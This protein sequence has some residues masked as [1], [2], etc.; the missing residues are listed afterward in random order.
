MVFIFDLYVKTKSNKYIF[1]DSKFSKTIHMKLNLS[2]CP[3]KDI[4]FIGNS[5]GYYH[6]STDLFGKHGIK[7]YNYSVT[8][9][10]I[11]DFLWM[12]KETIKFHPKKIALVF[13]INELYEQ[14]R[15]TRDPEI[16]DILA[17]I[18]S[19]QSY[20]FIFQ[21]S[22]EY[23][24]SR[25]T[26]WDLSANVLLHIQQLFDSFNKHSL[27][28]HNVD[29]KNTDNNSLGF[30]SFSA[31]H[32]YCAPTAIE[33]F[34]NKQIIKC[35]NGDGVLIGNKKP[36]NYKP[37]IKPNKNLDDSTLR[38]LNYILFFIKKNKIY[39]VVILLPTANNYYQYDANLSKIKTK[40]IN[41][42]NIRI[43]KN[44]WFD[45]I[46]MNNNGRIY[47]STILIKYLKNEN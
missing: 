46:H 26:I 32:L 27:L 29:T 40:V 25:N 20:K 47:L 10:H 23:L 11:S 34:A 2:D 8:D 42:S 14:P 5:Q 36:N 37:T 9:R 18:K 33:R 7:I 1:L 45:D 16:A 4:V 3:P 19:D 44:D 17:Y 13:N 30:N 24:K 6:I 35:S 38:L 28:Y 15:I 12:V 22:I 31:L 39:S 41:L 21:E 43:P